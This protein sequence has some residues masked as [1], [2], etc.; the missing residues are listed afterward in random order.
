L[1]LRAVQQLDTKQQRNDV[2]WLSE[3]VSVSKF[4]GYVSTVVADLI[5]VTVTRPPFAKF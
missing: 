2:A 5:A 1:D 4:N 3:G